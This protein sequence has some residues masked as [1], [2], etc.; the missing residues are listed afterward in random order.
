VTRALGKCP[1]CRRQV[2][3][4][5]DRYTGVPTRLR[6]HYPKPYSYYE[7]R[8]QALPSSHCPGSAPKGTTT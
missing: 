2:P 1:V 6:A 7:K 5:N 8:R 4:V 3:L